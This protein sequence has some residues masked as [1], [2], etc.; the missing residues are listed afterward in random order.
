MVVFFLA[1]STEWRLSLEPIEMLN[2]GVLYE[3]ILYLIGKGQ[4]EESCFSNNVKKLMLLE[5]KHTE[6]FLGVCAEFCSETSISL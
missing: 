1:I 6:V 5:E 2:C 3:Y 4:N